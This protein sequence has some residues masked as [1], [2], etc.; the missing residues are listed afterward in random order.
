MELINNNGGKTSFSTVES[1]AKNCPVCRH[2]E[3]PNLEMLLAAGM[4][5]AD[6][7]EDYGLKIT[8]L[9]RHEQLHSTKQPVIDPLRILHAMRYLAEKSEQMVQESFENPVLDKEG[10][11][12]FNTRVRA[13]NLAKD[14]YAKYADL[15]DAP[16]HLDERVVL[17]RWT[18][19]I[20]TLG[21][22]LREVPGALEVLQKWADTEGPKKSGVTPKVVSKIPHLR[23]IGIIFDDDDV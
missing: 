9:R 11:K 2:P 21:E 19:V 13:I 4:P 1:L 20:Q 18:Q 7:K 3:R 8:D 23:D 17:P 5:Y 12:I 15:I 16:R 6:L 22:K 14:I 10:E